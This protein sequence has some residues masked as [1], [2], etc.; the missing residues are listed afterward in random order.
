MGSIEFI[1][2][3]LVLYYFLVSFSLVLACLKYSLSTEITSCSVPPLFTAASEII[4]FF[5]SEAGP[6]L[7]MKR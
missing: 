6:G 3:L 2:Y 1:F 4:S 5:L 7:P